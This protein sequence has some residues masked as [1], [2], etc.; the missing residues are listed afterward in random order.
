MAGRTEDRSTAIAYLPTSRKVT[1]DMSRLS[2]S[3]AKAGWF[4]PRTG[5]S[6]AAGDFPATGARDFTPPGKGTGSWCWMAQAGNCPR[7]APAGKSPPAYCRLT[8]CA[9]LN[10]GQ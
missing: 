5:Q 1:V 4:D 3:D 2:G 6:S 10:S 8:A 7:P 9:R